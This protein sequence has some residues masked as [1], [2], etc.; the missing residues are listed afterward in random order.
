MRVGYE[1]RGTVAT[2]T[3]NDGKLNV[4]SPDMFTELNAALDRAQ[5]D[6]A[7]VILTGREGAFSAGFDMKVLGA[8]PEPARA[9]AVTGF[10]L[11]ARILA[12]PTPVVIACPG[13]TIAMGLFLA[14]SGDYRIG[15]T[16]AY[17]IVANEVA[18]GITMPHFALELCRQRLSPTHFHR[19]MMTAEMLSPEDA[20]HA[21]I[22]DRVV[23]AGELHDTA[24]LAASRL[25]SLPLHV[26]AATKARARERDLAAI[27]A[28]IQADAA[29]FG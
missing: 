24:R 3:M 18:I 28:A 25:A 16:G 5:A 21:G 26:Y 19:V 20:V 14:L 2:I 22:F 1:L 12:F 15:A 6:R 29:T 4:L 17:K 9:L 10:E 11:A 13:H 8:G 7:V 23:P 27:R